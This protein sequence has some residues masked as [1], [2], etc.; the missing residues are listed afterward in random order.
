M[1]KKKTKH[2]FIDSAIKIHG[3]K[4]DYSIVSYVNNKTKVKIICKE[5]G[6]FE[7]KPNCILS[8]RGC[9]KCG[10][11]NC[12]DKNRKNNWKA[13]FE[14]IHG[15]K[16]DYSKVIYINNK[17]NIEVIC[18]NHGSFIIRPDAHIS[19]KQG[20]PKCSYF[21]VRNTADF[22]AESNKI[23]NNRYF[24]D[25]VEYENSHKEVNIICP[26]HGTFNIR[27]N[28]HLSGNGC[29]KCSLSKG[30][31]SIIGILEDSKIEY[32]SQYK[33][34]KCLSGN[35]IKLR[36]DFYLPKYNLCIEY[37]GEQHYKPIV[38][39]GGEENFIE[40]KKRDEIKDL[41]CVE[42]SIYLLRISFKDYSRIF[43]ILTTYLKSINLI[44]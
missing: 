27:P 19:Q 30:E 28:S 2:E 38:F 20:C 4:Y 26:E 31:K 11:I 42:N 13:S 32:V 5:H 12:G 15:N 40:Q 1:P 10:R 36:F 6:I 25:S 44:Y 22:I 3:Y 24:Y 33:F 16:Y 29:P 18:S 43:D 39:F 37:D 8:G 35:N 41:F 7:S 21:K 14:K 9:P 34:D 23:H 17:T